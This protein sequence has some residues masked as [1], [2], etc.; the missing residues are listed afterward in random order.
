M[1]ATYGDSMNNIPNTTMRSIKSLAG[2]GALLCA[3]SLPGYG[4]TITLAEYAFNMDGVVS[5]PTIGDV[6][7]AAVNI[8]GFNTATGL[9]TITVTMGGV[10]AH[11]FSLFLDH[12]IVEDLNTFFNEI[13]TASGAP[14]AGQSWEI[15][16]PGW[17]FGD[18]YDNFLVGTLDNSNGVPDTAPDDVSMALGWNF[19]LGADET[20]VLSF[21][22]SETPPNAGFYL[23]QTDPDSQQSIFFSS[24]LTIRGQG[25]PDG[26]SSLVLLLGAMTGLVGWRSRR[27]A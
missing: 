4:A 25:V 26:G 14:A 17:V 13:G 9:G 21:N 11:G 15:D 16:E 24:S 12:E 23:M 8:S 2:A 20:G 1:P 10:G 6:V 22:V 7:P 18:I 27:K 19:T 5:N 3:A